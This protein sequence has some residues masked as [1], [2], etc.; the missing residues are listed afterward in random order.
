MSKDVSVNL[1]KRKTDYNDNYLHNRLILNKMLLCI[2]HFN[3]VIVMY[4]LLH[5]VCIILSCV[6]V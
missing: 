5:S 6:P 4:S 3:I 1:P 2:C